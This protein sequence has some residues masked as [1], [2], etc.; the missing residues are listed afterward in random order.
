[1][2]RQLILIEV[3]FRTGIESECPMDCSNL[4]LAAGPWTQQV[5][6]DLFPSNSIDLKAEPNAAD[7]L[8]LKNLRY[9]AVCSILLEEIVHHKLEFAARN[10]GTIWAC[11]QR[12]YRTT[13]DPPVEYPHLIPKS[14]RS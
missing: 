1:M 12:V 5:L 3:W 7:W 10:D 11:N 13:I 2:V 9:P 4:I 6:K 8:I 14:L